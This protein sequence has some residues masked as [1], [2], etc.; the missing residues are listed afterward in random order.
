MV[1]FVRP[2]LGLFTLFVLG[3]T[4]SAFGIDPCPTTAQTFEITTTAEATE[5]ATAL[6]CS[7]GGTF[8]VLW[9]G[10]VVVDETFALTDGSVVTI[11]GVGSGSIVDGGG[12]TQLFTVS[13]ATL[14]LSEIGLENGSGTD[15]NADISGG[16][17]GAIGVSGPDSAVF[18]TGATSFNSNTANTGGA[19]SVK[20]GAVVSWTGGTS[21]HGNTASQVFGG[22]VSVE[23]GSSVSW[24]GRTNFTGNVASIRGGA[25]YSNEGIVVFAG[26]TFFADNVA[27]TGGGALLATFSDVSWSDRMSFK[28]NT[29]NTARESGGTVQVEDSVISW[30][31]ETSFYGGSGGVGGA[32]HVTR[33]SAVWKGETTFCDNVVELRGGALSVEISS[34]VSWTGETLFCN[35][36]V[37]EN[38]IGGGTGGAIHVSDSTVSWNG[39]TTFT[40]NTA[41]T[42]GALYGD[43]GAGMIWSGATAYEKNAASANGGAVALTGDVLLDLTTAGTSLSLTGNTAGIAGGG[44]YQSNV[45]KG[46]TWD[47]VSFISNSALNGGA[48]YSVGTGAE[49]EGKTT[50]PS[51]FANCLF[52]GNVAEVSGGAMESAA[53]NDEFTNSTFE[54]N[55]AGELGGGLRVAGTT[56]LTG[57][58]FVGN[59]AGGEGPAVANVGTITMV[60]TSFTDNNLICTSGAFLNFTIEASNVSLVPPVDVRCSDYIFQVS[61]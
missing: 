9:E 50:Y 53:G 23:N 19:V 35:N 25:L 61:K 18:C 44:M 26:E 52:R 41:V 17:G 45:G 48:V 20:N 56:T 37:D 24:D 42:G 29:L 16:N 59:G 39:T 2:R 51:V 28:N 27:R 10:R 55:T 34:E 12:T 49:T 1:L 32:L 13:D 33:S 22:A 8:D 4:R 5:L 60:N 7:G 57:C 58:D 21:F 47:S 31:G 3:V 36:T 14:E 15:G 11:A 6:N 43:V 54:G 46:L 30:D 38:F 40:D